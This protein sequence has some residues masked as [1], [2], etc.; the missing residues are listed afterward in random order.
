MAIVAKVARRIK[1]QYGLLVARCLGALLGVLTTI[2]MARA[3]EAS[4]FGLF[5]SLLALQQLVIVGC[6]LGLAQW[7]VA[8]ADLKRLSRMSVAVRLR[9]FV[10]VA[11]LAVGILIGSVVLE[12]P[13]GPVVVMMLTVP[14][15]TASILIAELQRQMQ[16]GKFTWL[17]TMQSAAW[18][19]AVLL[20][21]ASPWAA[22]AFPYVCAFTVTSLFYFL[23][24]VRLTRTAWAR[25]DGEAAPSVGDLRQTLINVAPLG[26]LAV[27]TV[28]Y[29]KGDTLLV[30]A[31]LGLE[32][33]GQ[34]AAAYR[35]FEQLQIIPVSLSAVVF[36]VL[37]A[38]IRNRSADLQAT[39]TR[40]LEDMLILLLPL[41]VLVAVFA[42]PLMR[43]IYGRQY[44]DSYVLLRVLAPAIVLL[45]AGYILGYLATSL[46]AY[47]GRLIVAL[48]VLAGSVLA[49][50]ALLG[51]LGVIVACVVTLAGEAMGLFLLAVS[52]RRH[53]APPSAR[54]WLLS[55]SVVVAHVLLWS[56]STA[57]VAASVAVAL[58][59]PAATITS[60]VLPTTRGRRA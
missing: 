38:K 54:L 6:D 32:Q 57:L 56:S 1:P 33:A 20:V 37:A 5:V 15:S 8:S 12:F 30:S 42:Q 25:K 19:A 28:V 44:A 23:V 10:G 49:N 46:Q 43:L 52:L 36:P 34:Y 4:E 59:V 31:I 9:L 13:L 17:S 26:L 53:L 3:M 27:V 50:V 45:G 40:S 55:F 14:L 18:L 39:V 11:C 58:A 51:R 24:V 7:V 60:R 47:W 21:S 41:S 48:V 2:V 35:L 16:F 29:F 22:S